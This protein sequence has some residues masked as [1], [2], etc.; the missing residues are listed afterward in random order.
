M[1]DDRKAM[2]KLQNKVES[3]RMDEQRGAR[4]RSK[5]VATWRSEKPPVMNNGS[6]E[7]PFPKK[8]Q[9]KGTVILI[10]LLVVL[11]GAL[12]ML[13]NQDRVTSAYDYIA[14]DY[15]WQRAHHGE[16]ALY[17]LDDGGTVQASLTIEVMERGQV[18]RLSNRDEVVQKIIQDAFLTVGSSEVRSN[19][20]KD[21]VVD[22][23]RSAINQEVENVE[24]KDVYFRSILT[25]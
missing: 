1:T 7:E 4:N 15:S 20:G 24:V 21:R 19:E 8:K 14:G 22:D 23:I 3:K 18:R 13:L 25:P 17:Q 5:N 11:G 10:G 12:L 9:N 6:D 16:E 2:E